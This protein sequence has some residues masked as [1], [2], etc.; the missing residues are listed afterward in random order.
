MIGITTYTIDEILKVTGPVEVPAYDVT[1][2]PGETTLKA[3]QLTRAAAP[4]EDRKAFLPAFADSLIAA[5][6]SLPAQSWDALPGAAG[7]L[8][9]GRHLL[10]WFPDPADQALAARAGVDGAV[11][12]DRGDY[13]FPVD[14][15][16]SPASKLNAWTSRTLDLEVQLDEF[17]NAHNSLE[18]T[19]SNAVETE[20]GAPFR[21]MENVGGHILGMYFRLLVPERSRVESVTGGTLAPVTLPAVVG[22]EAGRTVIG[23]YVKVPAGST[24]LRYRWT[25]PYAADAESDGGSYRLTMQ[26]QPG[27]LP[28]PLRLTIRVPDGTRITAASPELSVSGTTATL[29]ATFDRDLV[30]GL[31]VRTLTSLARVSP[32]W[33]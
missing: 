23:A 11:R 6:F 15:N 13:L 3:L 21:E 1:I 27:M 30:V 25:S 4:G 12:Q 16:V 17:G 5:V 26:A 9:D 29:T 20:A 10:A 7:A 14:A 28:G 8:R 24:T 33:S 18:T 19:W 2:A 32:N 22:E 31:R